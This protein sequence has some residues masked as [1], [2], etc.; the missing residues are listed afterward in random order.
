VSDDDIGDI[1]DI[2]DSNESGDDLDEAGATALA[3]EA[4][5]DAG[6]DPADYEDPEVGTDGVQWR[7]FFLGR[8]LRPGDHFEIVIDAD[9]GTRIVHGR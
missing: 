1:G 2:G 9:G 4:A 6:Y 3:L 8:S 5:R 7:A